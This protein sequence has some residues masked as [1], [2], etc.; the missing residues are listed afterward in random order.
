M[1]KVSTGYDLKRVNNLNIISIWGIIV[2]L[3]IQE[4]FT[5]SISSAI[6]TLFEAMFIGIVA[7][8]AFFLPVERYLKGVIMNLIPVLTAFFLCASGGVT[9]AEYC[10]F[11]IAIS[12]VALYFKKELLI[13]FAV[14]IDVGL[15]ILSFITPESFM[16]RAGSINE[17]VSFLVMLNGLIVIIYLLTKWGSDLLIATKKNE[18]HANGLLEQLRNAMQKADY[19]SA[20]LNDNVTSFKNNIKFV[21][22]SN[23][24]ITTAM[25]EIAQGIGEES[26]SVND[27]NDK[28][29]KAT[30]DINDCR[31]LS[32]QISLVS[33]NM[34]INVDQGSN[35]V[36]K[37]DN[38]MKVI[39]QA[40]STS[41]DTVE[42]LQADIENINKFL[43][44]ISQISDQTNL[45]ALNA[46]IEAARAGEQGRGF[47]IVADEVRKLAEQSAVAAR[48][49]NQIIQVITTRTKAAVDEVNKGDIAVRE[50]NNLV[51]DVLDEFEEIRDSVRKAYDFIGKEESMVEGIANM[52][53]KIQ[54]QLQNIAL[55]SAEHA[56]STEEVLA[57]VETQ[58][59][60]MNSINELVGK[61]QSLSGELNQL[62]SVNKMR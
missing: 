58:N 42:K 27:I 23:S 52:F 4:F 19:T 50:G 47:A 49:I 14:I 24:N 41:M 56:A 6:S 30:A 8:I 3:I 5:A 18:E 15:I 16:K 43:T 45:L 44:G 20:T 21:R 57:A 37:V 55:I 32:K 38:Q 46:A 53:V 33:N 54:E 35:K 34:S 39:K 59:E 10:I 22:E 61:I 51:K 17:F 26:R 1:E 48:E 9:L 29:V 2:V 60:N 13:T 62:S 7:T 40:V 11:F 25:Q 12:L 28:M 31:Q 36:L